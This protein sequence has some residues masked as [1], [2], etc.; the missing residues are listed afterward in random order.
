MMMYADG[1]ALLI[2]HG[3]EQELEKTT[4]VVLDRIAEYIWAEVIN[5]YI[6]QLVAT[7]FYLKALNILKLN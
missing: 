5:T 7:G 4:I 1:L 6:L 3:K 2:V